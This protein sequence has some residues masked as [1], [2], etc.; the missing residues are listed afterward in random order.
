MAEADA[1]YFIH[2]RQ[3]ELEITYHLEGIRADSS[4][5]V[6]MK[7]FSEEN[8]SWPMEKASDEP[9]LLLY[10]GRMR[11][12]PNQRNVVHI[13]VEP[14]PDQTVSK[15][16]D[17]NVIDFWDLSQKACDGGDIV[18]TRRV[19]FTAYE[20]A[21]VVD[22]AK[23]GAYDQDD[24]VYRYY[25]RT[26]EFAELTP[27]VIALARE[28]VG[29]E[30]N[31]YLQARAI[32]DWCVNEIDYVYPP[33]RGLRYCLPRRTGD[34]G[35]YSL[36]FMSLCR[37]VGIPARVANGHW[38]C[39]PKKNYHVWNEFYITGYGWLPADAT[40]GRITRDT[41]GKLAGNGDE[42]YYF[43]NL[44]SGRFITSKGTSIQLYPAPPWNR[45]GL[46]DANRNPIFF[47][48]AA[49][50]YANLQIERQYVTVEII[51]GEDVLW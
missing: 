26:Q 30:S 35:S 7:E 12:Y 48:T 36:I 22:P 28:I 24:P 19:R 8:V 27:D 42:S 11:D 6:F 9:L 17:G 13:S 20:T 38:C 1:K 2:P 3:V 5:C 40:D 49:T 39:A 41:P 32:Y 51:Q 33:D 4:G 47:Q 31:P 16:I 34:C 45:W 37:A 25:T 18:V 15:D 43:G 14:A 23:V 21:F 46:A 44:D 10:A 50:V 29:D